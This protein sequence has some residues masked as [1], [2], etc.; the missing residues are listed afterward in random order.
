M[1][2][3]DSIKGIFEKKDIFQK[4]KSYA[5]EENTSKLVKLTKEGNPMEVRLAAIDA[6]KEIKMDD[7]CVKTLMDLLKDD[8]KEIIIAACMSLKRVGTKRE[9]EEL[10]FKSEQAEDEE[11]KKALSAAAVESKERTPR[12]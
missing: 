10:R 2:L 7:L 4:I 12:F 9:T 3:I 11:I 1:G 5:E 8:T 6:L